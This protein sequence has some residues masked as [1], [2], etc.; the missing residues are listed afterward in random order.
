M[1]RFRG[2]REPKEPKP[3]A[4]AD[5]SRIVKEIGSAIPPPNGNGNGKH[6]EAQPIQEPEYVPQPAAHE[7]PKEVQDY[8]YHGK[9]HTMSVNFSSELPPNLNLN[10]ADPKAVE[11]PRRAAP[12]LKNIIERMSTTQSKPPRPILLYGMIGFIACF[13]GGILYSMTYDKWQSSEHDFQLQWLKAQQIS[14]NHTGT[15]IPPSAAPKPTPQQGGGP[16]VC[17]INPLAPPVT[18]C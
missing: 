5:I 14:G 11:W 10:F 15:Y 17:I 18:H 3:A 8:D 12:A 16:N 4:E 7:V 2:P 1:P 9:A 13:G 6:V